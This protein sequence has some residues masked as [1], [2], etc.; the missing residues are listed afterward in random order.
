[1]TGLRR[2]SAMAAGGTYHGCTAG[3]ATPLN[4]AIDHLQHTQPSLAIELVQIHIHDGARRPRGRCHDLTIVEADYC[5]IVWYTDA[6]VP[7]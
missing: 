4:L 2:G 6:A 7:P 5:N 1:M 3:R